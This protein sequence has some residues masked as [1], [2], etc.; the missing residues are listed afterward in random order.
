MAHGDDSRVF[1]ELLVLHVQSGDRR[2]LERLAARW[3][4]RL[5]AT[6][7]RLT[8]EADAARE[9]VQE[10]WAG[11]VRGLPRLSD[12]AKFPAWA[13]GIL[14][15]KCADQISFVQTRRARFA[16][17]PEQEPPAPR[18][19]D[20]TVSDI[21]RA[22]DALS[23]DHRIAATLFF[24]EGLSLIEVAAAMEVPV[25]TAKSRIFHARKHLKSLLKGDDDV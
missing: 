14:R 20:G 3:Q 5:L 24:A 11:I 1:D 2:A 19:P 4:P 23:P 12:P 9:V 17:L 22:F 16:E 21:Q 25:G 10:T 13:F 7:R 8:G 6:A 15:R 18:A